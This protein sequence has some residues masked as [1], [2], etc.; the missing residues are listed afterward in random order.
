M[1]RQVSHDLPYLPEVV[2]FVRQVQ[3]AQHHPWLDLNRKV[4]ACVA[5]SLILPEA[6]TEICRNDTKCWLSILLCYC[7]DVASSPSSLMIFDRRMPS[8]VMDCLCG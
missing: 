8:N 1:L 2:V 3:D 7:A 4:R 6:C 5:A